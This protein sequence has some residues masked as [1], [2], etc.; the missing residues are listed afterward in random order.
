MSRK[1][2]EKA[3][4]PKL[5][6]KQ[7]DQDQGCGSDQYPWISFR[8]MTANREHSLAFLG[9]LDLRDRERTQAGLLTRL[10][11]ISR[12]PWLYWMGMQKAAGLETLPADELEFLPGYGAPV[13]KDMT[14]YIFRFDTYQGSKKGRIIGFKLAPCSAYHIIG[15]DMNFSAYRH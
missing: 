3:D 15:Y 6:G 4:A 10:D 14:L 7:K 1:L 13:T 11:E 8:Y 5:K 12:F 2:R 9:S